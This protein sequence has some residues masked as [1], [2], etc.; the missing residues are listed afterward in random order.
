MAVSS[1]T[2]FELLQAAAIDER[3]SNVRYR[4]NELQSLHAVLRSN[5][6]A[7]CNAIKKDSQNRISDSI[8]ESEYYLAM[9]A[10][11]HFYEELDFDKALITEYLISTGADNPNRRVGNGIVIIR[12]TTHTRVYSIICPLAAAIAAGNCVCLEVRIPEATSCQI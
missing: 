11:T 12:P 5:A 3:T 4:Q 6:D 9:D 1:E 10:I 7:I 8:S 2:N